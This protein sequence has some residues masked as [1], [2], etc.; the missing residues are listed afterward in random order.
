MAFQAQVITMTTDLGL[1]MEEL[2]HGATGTI[3]SLCVLFMAGIG[4][5]FVWSLAPQ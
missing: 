3:R 5:F 4:Q 1:V 2:I